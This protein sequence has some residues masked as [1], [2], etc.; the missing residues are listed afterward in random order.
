[1]LLYIELGSDVYNWFLLIWVGF[2]ILLGGDVR[3]IRVNFKNDWK[4]VV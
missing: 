1:M 4:M 3:L 2:I